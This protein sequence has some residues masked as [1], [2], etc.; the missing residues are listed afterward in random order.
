MEKGGREG[1]IEPVREGARL[2]IAG[3]ADWS[4]QHL[5]EQGDSETETRSGRAPLR[6][7][8][9]QKGRKGRWWPT[10]SF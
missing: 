8:K 2:S 5:K 10:E 3:R 7:G 9:R 4:R 1:E 6:G